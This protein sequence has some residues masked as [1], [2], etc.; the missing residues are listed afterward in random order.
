MRSMGVE[1]EERE[2][3]QVEQQWEEEEHQGW[4]EEG[5]EEQRG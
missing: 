5:L 4:Q 3:P 2:E 1:E